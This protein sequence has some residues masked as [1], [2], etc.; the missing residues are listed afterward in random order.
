MAGKWVANTRI[1]VTVLD[2]KYLIRG[3]RLSV[4]KGFIAKLL[5]VNPIIT[6][7]ETGKAVVGDKSFSPK[8]NMERAMR[9]VRNSLKEKPIWNYIVM[10]ANNPEAAAWYT[11]KMEALIGR[12]PVCV[13][14]ISPIIGANAGVG[15]S[16]VAF[17][18]E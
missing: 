3:G 15:A 7:D 16:A 5:H 14:N 9:H 11:S 18:N 12:N 8:A 10:H 13:M 2:L 4:T 1:L 6:L 17:M